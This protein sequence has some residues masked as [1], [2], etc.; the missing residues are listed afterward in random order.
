MRYSIFLSVFLVLNGAA[1][2]AETTPTWNCGEEKWIES[3]SMV[4]GVFMGSLTVDC[5]LIGQGGGG[6]VA[7]EKYI[8]DTIQKTRTLHGKPAEEKTENGRLVRFDVTTDVKD[9][10]APVAMR[11]EVTIRT[12]G[13]KEL[14]YATE[15]KEISASGMASYLKKV[16]FMAKIEATEQKNGDQK[17]TYKMTMVNSVQVERPWY[18]L[19]L[20]FYP[21][22]KQVSIDKFELAREKMI[23]KIVENL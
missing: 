16:T 7:L 22:A 20:I 18:A 2:R 11:E 1:G 19:G 17:S 13:K 8:S 14:V 4:D 9:E 10:G 23:P 15:S 21:I 3:P 12:D 5:E 6:F